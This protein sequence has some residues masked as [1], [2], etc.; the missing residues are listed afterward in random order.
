MEKAEFFI[1]L[2]FYPD[3]I[4]VEHVFQEFK[5]VDNTCHSPKKAE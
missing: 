1:G 4:P 3:L 5:E 2:H